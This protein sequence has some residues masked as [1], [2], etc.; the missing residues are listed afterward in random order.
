MSHR[1]PKPPKQMTGGNQCAEIWKPG[2]GQ[3]QLV[4]PLFQTLEWLYSTFCQAQR[5]RRYLGLNFTK[6]LQHTC[7]RERLLSQPISSPILDYSILWSLSLLAFISGVC[8]YQNIC[9]RCSDLSTFSLHG[10]LPSVWL[11]FRW[12]I[13][14]SQEKETNRPN[15][16]EISSIETNNFVWVRK[17]CPTWITWCLWTLKKVFNSD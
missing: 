11:I 3:H 6:L 14:R 17:D 9:V 5:E 15:R 13:P 2:E 1:K 10:N 12:P 8:L 16:N 7:V 4:R